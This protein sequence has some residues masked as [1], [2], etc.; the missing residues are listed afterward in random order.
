M[1]FL[2]RNIGKSGEGNLTNLPPDYKFKR[3]LVSRPNH[4][5]GNLLLM[6]PLLQEISTT[7]PGC[8]IDVFVKGNLGSILFENYGNVDRII[9]LP[10]KPFKELSKY[11]ISWVKLKKNDY[12]LIINVTNNSSSGRLSTSLANS[13]LKFFSDHLEDLEKKYPDYQHIAK[14]PVYNFRNYLSKMGLKPKN[15]PV[16]PLDLKLSPSEI[17]QGKVLLDDLVKNEKPTILIFTYATG[18]KCYSVEWWE[19]FYSKLQQEFQDEYNIVE[20]L[21]VENVSQIGFKAPS[22]YSKDVREIGA[23]MTNAAVFIGADSGIMHLASSVNVPT[24]GLFMGGKEMYYPYNSGSQAIDTREVEI[25]E[26]ILKIRKE[27]L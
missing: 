4:R 8:K 13:D 17:S 1:R 25:P 23:F 22:F 10:R 2:T 19:E 12:D 24:L 26:I 18:R 9:K 5:L 3:I 6:T 14:K 27:V 7:F 11:L 15:E 16:K 21:P 20:V